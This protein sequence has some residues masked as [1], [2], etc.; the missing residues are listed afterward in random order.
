[1]SIKQPTGINV[2]ITDLEK[3][4]SLNPRL[5]NIIHSVKSASL[6]DNESNYAEYSFN[7][8]HS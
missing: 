7:S 6:S 5:K 2:K 3:L 8:S 1:M 4:N